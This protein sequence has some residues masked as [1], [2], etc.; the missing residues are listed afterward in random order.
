M[1]VSSLSFEGLN[2]KEGRPYHVHVDMSDLLV[3]ALAVVLQD[4]V[5]DGARGD[6]EFLGY[7]LGGEGVS[8]WPDAVLQV[9]GHIYQ[10]LGQILV[11][12]IRQLLAVVLGDDEL[13]EPQPVSKWLCSFVIEATHRMPAAQGLDV[14]ERQRPFALK[15]LVGGNLP[16]IREAVSCVVLDRDR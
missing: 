5:L 7:G 12:D 16:W 2:W 1:D 13:S 6:G 15:E 3:G 10:E 14:E 11:R 8:L 4:V 9:K